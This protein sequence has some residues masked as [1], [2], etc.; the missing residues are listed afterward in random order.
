M[1]WAFASVEKNGFKEVGAEVIATDIGSFAL[2]SWGRIKNKK[3]N[4]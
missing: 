2:A 1:F 4:K 3:M